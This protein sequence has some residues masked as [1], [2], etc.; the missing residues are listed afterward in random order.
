[1]NGARLAYEEAGSGDPPFVFIHGW[2]CDRSA[3]RPQV[4]EMS[5]DHRCVA[6]DLR[7]R[8]ESEAIPPFDAVTAADDVAAIIR[9]LGLGAAILAGHSLG[10]VIALLVNDRHPELVTGIVVGDSPIRPSFAGFRR[11]SETVAEDGMLGAADFVETFFV[12]ET[13]EDLR[14][15]IR[16]LMLACPTDVAAGMLAG[17]EQFEDRLTDIVR[18]ADRKPFMAIWGA[19]P[20]GD[21]NWLREVCLFLRHEPVAEAGHFF[22]LEQPAI[23]NALLRAFLDDVVRDPRLAG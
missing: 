2:A 14:G 10:G 18:A 22:Q 17:S 16:T 6:V 21:I 19:S 3:W 13:P 4:E 7:G 9:D 5:R 12:E 15:K 8:G 11:M 1:M 23:T 20:L